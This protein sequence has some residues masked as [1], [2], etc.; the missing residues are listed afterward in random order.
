MVNETLKPAWIQ[1]WHSVVAVVVVAIVVV[2]LY[3]TRNSKNLL[4]RP[5]Y[6]F[7]ANRV[8]VCELT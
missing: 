1:F 7:I 2:V 3:I 6:C 5:K 8:W 4:Q